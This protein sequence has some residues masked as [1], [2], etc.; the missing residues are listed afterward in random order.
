MSSFNDII[1]DGSLLSEMPVEEL[2][3]FLLNELV[4][5]SKRERHLGSYN[6]MLGLQIGDDDKKTIMEA[7]AW[8]E[9]EGCLAPDYSQT[10]SGWVFVTRRGKSLAE[11]FD[12]KTPIGGEMLLKSILHVDIVNKAWPPFTRREFDTA[13]FQSVKR[14]EVAVRKAAK[15]DA[16]FVGTNLMR[17]AFDPSNGPLTNKHAVPAE[18]EALAHLFAGVVGYLRNPSGHRDVAVSEQ[19]AIYT[20]VIASQLLSIVDSKPYA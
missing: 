2:S 19:E 6:F 17:K 1:K 15:L 20:M 12:G 4:E 10:S 9:R 5:R 13:V 11:S 14:V 3:G 16:S 7:W 18:K 8:L